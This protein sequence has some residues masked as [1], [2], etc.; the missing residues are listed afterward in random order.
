MRETDKIIHNMEA[1]NSPADFYKPFHN[2][3]EF[4]LKNV[5]GNLEKL[6]SWILMKLSYTCGTFVW[7]S[8]Q[9]RLR[10]YTFDQ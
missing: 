1:K 2:K 3:N 9:P 4:R 10:K 5:H 7:P 8:E 6:I